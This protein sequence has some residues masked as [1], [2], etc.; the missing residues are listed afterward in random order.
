MKSAS[1]LLAFLFAVSSAVGASL[2]SYSG[3]LSPLIDPA[4]LA[5]LKKRAANPRIQKSVA[6]LE[7][8]RQ[9]GHS[10]A[11]VSADA[12]KRAGYTNA[13]LAQMTSAGLVRN[14]DIATKLGVVNA[15]GLERMRRGNAAMVT[16]GPYT[17]D[18]T[19]IDHI[20]PVAIVPELDNVVANLELMPGKLNSSK[21]DKMGDRQRDYCRRFQA[22]GML[23]SERLAGIL[24]SNQSAP[25]ASKPRSH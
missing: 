18:T 10:V 11:A 24:K 16:L 3:K 12:V 8:A 14:H 19:S 23:T 17:G 20:V 9:D 15:E 21:G 6:I 22:A 2:E 7:D 13:V 25:P 5:T 4:K 1:L